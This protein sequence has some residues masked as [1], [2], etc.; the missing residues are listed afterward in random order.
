MQLGV[1][2]VIVLLQALLIA[3]LL[4]Q[5]ARRRRAEA[6]LRDAE[7]NS[8]RIMDSTRA[9]PWV[10]DV[11]TWNCTY[12]G[13]QAVKVFGFPLERWYEPDFWTLHIHPEDRAAAIATCLGLRG[14]RRLRARLPHLPDSS[15]AGAIRRARVR[16]VNRGAVIG[17]WSNGF[18][19]RASLG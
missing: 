14:R 16:G 17:P 6:A 13:P 12:V 1:V 15:D 5:A 3:A 8:R 18:A 9:V 7:D 19:P 4:V 11:A 2:A 10:A